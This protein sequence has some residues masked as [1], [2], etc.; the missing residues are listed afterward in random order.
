MSYPKPCPKCQ[1]KDSSTI[2]GY[3]DGAFEEAIICD[4]CKHTGPFVPEK[5]LSDAVTAWNGEV[6]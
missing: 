5:T 2:W 6:T 3:R 4:N 1:S